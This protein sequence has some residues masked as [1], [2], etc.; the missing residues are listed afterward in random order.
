MKLVT[1]APAGAA[2]RIGALAEGAIVDLA[3][4]QPGFPG[5]MIELLRQGAAGTARAREALAAAAPRHCHAPESVRLLA[6]VPRPGTILGV[7]RNYGAHAAEG[8]LGAQ[9]KPRIFVELASTV[10]GTGVGAF[11]R[12]PRFLTPGDVIR[13]EIAEIGVLENRVV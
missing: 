6:P 8:G 3:A 13:M 12:P 11:R 2:P 1:F 10:I 9:E 4:A 5:E 7:G